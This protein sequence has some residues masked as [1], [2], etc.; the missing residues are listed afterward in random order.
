MQSTV[1]FVFM[2]IYPRSGTWKSVFITQLV[3]SLTAATPRAHHATV[4]LYDGPGIY[5][6]CVGKSYPKINAQIRTGRREWKGRGDK[7]NQY[8]IRCV[9]AG[10]RGAW[11]WICY[12]RTADRQ[13][14]HPH[15]RGSIRGGGQQ[16]YWTAW[17]LTIGEDRM[18]RSHGTGRNGKQVLENWGCVPNGT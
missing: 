18:G 8:N 4:N 17:G 10:Q 5:G 11:K 9:T 3:F 14:A 15:S 2:F 16:C 13:T 6:L 12:W 1:Q 7:S